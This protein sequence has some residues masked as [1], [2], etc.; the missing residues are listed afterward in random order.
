MSQLIKV[1]FAKQVDE[2]LDFDKNLN[3]VSETNQ[4]MDGGS[5]LKYHSRAVKSLAGSFSEAQL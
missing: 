2:P 5:E 3:K 4:V 1:K